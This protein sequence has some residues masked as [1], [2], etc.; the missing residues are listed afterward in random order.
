MGDTG[1][2]ERIRDIR[3]SEGRNKIRDPKPG[4]P[5]TACVACGRVLR[6]GKNGHPRK[7][8]PIIRGRRAD[9][10]QGTCDGTFMPGEPV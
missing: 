8:A 5:I 7:H 9:S 2:L 6:M 1:K 3:G 4:G 10:G